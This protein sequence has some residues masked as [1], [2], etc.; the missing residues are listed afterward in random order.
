[1]GKGI[2]SGFGADASGLDVHRVIC[3]FLIRHFLR[4]SLL[5]FSQS[6]H[7]YAPCKARAASAMG[8]ARMMQTWREFLASKVSCVI[9]GGGNRRCRGPVCYV[10]YVS[11]VY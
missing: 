2:G 11:M 9:V 3:S 5:P 8:S 4:L 10:V 6:L 1:M 7:I